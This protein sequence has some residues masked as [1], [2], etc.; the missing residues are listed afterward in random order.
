MLAKLCRGRE[1]PDCRTYPRHT[2]WHAERQA[3]LSRH[4]IVF[5]G[6][7]P[8]LATLTQREKIRGNRPAGS[9]A[10]DAAHVH[11]GL[12]Y[13]LE[14]DG[15]TPVTDMAQTLLTHLQTPRP[16]SCFFAG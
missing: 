1:R 3:L 4:D 13:D 5:V 6:L 14:F 8:P 11:D 15:S 10:R 7:R 12:L 9:A 2:R 16:R